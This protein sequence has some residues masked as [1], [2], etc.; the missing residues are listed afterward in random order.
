MLHK[1]WNSKGDVPFCFPRSSIKFQGHTVQN[2][3]DFDPNWAFPDYRHVA[4]FKSLRFALLWHHEQGSILTFKAT[5]PVGQVRL[6]IYLS[7]MKWHLSMQLYMLLS[8]DYWPVLSD[9][10]HYNTT[11]PRSKFSKFLPVRDGRTKLKVEPWWDHDSMNLWPCVVCTRFD[12]HDVMDVLVW[13]LCL[14]RQQAIKIASNW[15][16]FNGLLPNQHP[17]I[18]L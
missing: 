15:G 16:N 8:S 10:C 18:P 13:H 2:I 12:C 17:Y 1:A 11:C 4:A 6:K 7:C 5:C 9:K 3:T 14:I